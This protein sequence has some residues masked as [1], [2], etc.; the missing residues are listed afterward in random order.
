MSTTTKIQT[1]IGDG[2][3]TVHAPGY[4]SSYR[5]ESVNGKTFQIKHDNGMRDGGYIHLVGALRTAVEELEKDI[6]EIDAE[7]KFREINQD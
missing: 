4:P 3:I 6:K 5:V 2:F 1:I 7:N